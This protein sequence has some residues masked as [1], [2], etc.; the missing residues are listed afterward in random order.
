MTNPNQNHNQ[1]QPQTA[2]DRSADN[3]GSQPRDNEGRFA[4]DGR[5]KDNSGRD[6]QRKPTPD[7]DKNRSG[8]PGRSQDDATRNR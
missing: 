3:R 8:Q 1:N 5:N 2:P 7:Q 4:D 6:P